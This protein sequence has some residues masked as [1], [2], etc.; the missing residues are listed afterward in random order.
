MPSEEC[1]PEDHL[2]GRA[3]AMLPAEN[4][5]HPED[6]D[7]FAAQQPSTVLP[8]YLALAY[9]ALV[10]YASLHPFSG[11][12]DLGLSPLA[13]LDAGWPRYWTAFDLAANVM[14]YLPLGFLLA[15]ALT[16]RHIPFPFSFPLSGRLIPIIVAA[17]LAGLLSLCLESLQTWLPA[18]VPSHV[19]LLCNGVGGGLGAL[20]TLWHG[21][22]F[23]VR[24]GSLQRRWLS[25]VPYAEL[26]LIILGSWLLTQLSPET[27]LFGAGDLRHLLYLTAAV[28][29]AAKSFFVIEM[30]ITVFNA[31]AIGLIARTLLTDR[32][33]PPTVLAIF[34]TLALTVRT[35]A[36][37]MLVTPYDALAW[38]TPGA[39]LGLLIGGVI[40]SLTLLL[41]PLPRLALAGLALMAGTV[42]VNLAPPNPYSAA[43]LATWQQ[44]HFL[45]F[46]GLTRLTASL[47]PF[48]AL[49]YLTMLARRW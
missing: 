36:A 7:D 37:A 26:G 6:T 24:A 25:P 45:N 5:T 39:S 8:H 13:F 22:R 19:D 1:P 43:A 42:L 17:L 20:L 11:W 28:P 18:R 35:L 23:F 47:W 16:V 48:L 30:A 49:P 44:G 15:L 3:P 14:A 2:V 32:A 9:A 40:L 46:N 41:P 34:F 29:Y 27:L 33:S 10:V 21:E 4:A 12:R 38:L 31:V